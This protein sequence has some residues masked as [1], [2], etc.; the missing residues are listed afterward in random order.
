VKTLLKVIVALAALAALGFAGAK[1]VQKRAGAAAADPIA[2]R[3]EPA[4]HGTLVEFISASGEI[5]A[6]TKVSIS[7]RVSARILELPFKEGDR[8][9]KGDPDSDPLIPPSILVKLDSKDLEASLKS[10]EARH[11]AEEASLKVS[12]QRVYAT[13]A[14]IASLKVT[15]ADAKR[16]LERQQ[17]LLESK[18]VSQQQVD[19]LQAKVDQQ[20]AEILGMFA[21]LKGDEG[22]LIVLQHQIEAAAAEIARAKDNLSYTTITSPIDGVVT[23]LNAEVGE[24]VVTGTMNNAGTVIMEVADLS[25]MVLKAR[26]DETS[27][28]DVK[29]SQKARIRMEAYRDVNFDGTVTKVALAN[30]DPSQARGAGNMRNQQNDGGKYYMAEILITPN[31]K[32]IFSGLSADADIQTNSYD[33]IIKVPSQ[34]V[35]GRAPDSLPTDIRNRPEVDTT[36][37]NIPVVYRYINGEAVVT[38]VAIGASDLTHTVI[39]SGLRAG[40]QIVTGPYKVLES[41]AHNQKIKPDHDATT[42]PT[43]TTTTQTTSP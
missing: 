26:V 43:T 41:L 20:E 17:K 23:R 31:G 42:K 29:V 38:P 34:A 15:L 18:D 6:R 27:I 1:W 5:E 33:G 13:Q 19:Q 22:G 16:E 36:K 28:A 35:L 14:R 8:V 12:E 11:A 30:F 10:A 3:I 21:T 40:E 4:V 37:A 25:Q 39:K 32:R 7:A 2:V 24:L 9:T